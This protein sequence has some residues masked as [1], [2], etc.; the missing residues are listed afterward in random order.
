MQQSDATSFR[1]TTRHRLVIVSLVISILCL[2][3]LVLF[4]YPRYFIQDLF[5][6]LHWGEIPA[7]TTFV[8][9]G[10]WVL[11]AFVGAGLLQ[12]ANRILARHI[13]TVMC[14]LLLFLIVY[15]MLSLV[16]VQERVNR[17]LITCSTNLR[18]LAIAYQVYIQ[19]HNERLPNT[20]E[21]IEC[22][23]KDKTLLICPQTQRYFHR[24][25]GYGYNAN[26]RGKRYM[27]ITDPEESLLLADAICPQSYLTTSSDIDRT[28]HGGSRQ[29]FYVVYLDGHPEFIASEADVHL[30]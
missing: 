4:F 27:S 17:R 24:I 16:F 23:V 20:W 18:Q 21:E 1:H 25:G 29:G 6:A 8:I 28:R 26:L 13:I 12:P 14:Y 2:A 7:G 15:G 22:N 5:D 30:K 9:G 11:A 10:V 3:V 19:D